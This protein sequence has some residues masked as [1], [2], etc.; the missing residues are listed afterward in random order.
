MGRLRGRVQYQG[1]VCAIFPEHRL[2][3]VQR[4]DIGRE[5]PVLA[6]QTGFE[7]RPAPVRAGFRAKEISPHVIVD[8]DDI[9]AFSSQKANSFSADQARRSG[10]ECNRHIS[11]QN[12]AFARLII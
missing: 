5:M 8:T 3:S 10:Y 11:S 4:A 1:D 9:K 2:Q 7:L 12:T 6:L